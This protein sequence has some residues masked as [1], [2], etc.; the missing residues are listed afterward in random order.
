MHYPLK[1]HAHSSW[2]AI[3]WKT[4]QVIQSSNIFFYQDT[5][6]LAYNW[7]DTSSSPSPSPPSSTTTTMTAVTTKV[8]A[9][10][11]TIVLLCNYSDTTLFK[12]KYTSF[13][14]NYHVKYSLPLANMK[15]KNNKK[16]NKTKQIR[17]KKKKKR[18]YEIQ[19]FKFTDTQTFI[20]V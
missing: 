15:K 14:E 19:S 11:I 18:D 6:F 7:I 3:C 12:R 1:L 9:A 8:M 10:I 5:L 2:N 16:Q 4:E 17:I 20:F 13:P